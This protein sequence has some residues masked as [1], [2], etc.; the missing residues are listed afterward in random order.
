MFTQTN[1]TTTNGFSWVSLALKVL[2]G[3]TFLLLMDLHVRTELGPTG[4][5]RQTLLLQ[6]GLPGQTKLILKSLKM[7][8][9]KET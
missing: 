2:L 6:V 7:N 3:R 9:L 1:I 5:L 4:L 8:V